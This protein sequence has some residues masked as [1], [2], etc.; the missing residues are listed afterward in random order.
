[1][2]R[3]KASAAVDFI[4]SVSSRV[5]VLELDTGLITRKFV[6]YTEGLLAK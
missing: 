2:T 3:W 5:N 6:P 4:R 1:M